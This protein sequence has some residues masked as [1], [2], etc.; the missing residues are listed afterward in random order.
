MRMMSA[1]ESRIAWTDLPADVRNGVQ[2][3]LGDRVVEALSQPGGFSPGTADRVRTAKG[4]RAFVK[5]VHPNLNEHSPGLHRREARINAALPVDV[6]APQ[7]IGGYDDGEWVA[8]VLE[9]IE[10]RHPVTPWVKV[11][12]D[13]VLAALKDLARTLTPPPLADLPSAR[14]EF[15]EDLRGW[16]RVAEDPPT[17]LDPWVKAN[18]SRL[19]EM[20]EPGIT[21]LDGDTGV[22]LDIRADNLLIRPDGRV[23]IIGWPWLCRGPAWLDSA[24]LMINVQLYRGHDID[25][26]LEGIARDFD[27]DIGALRGVL[28]GMAGFFVDAARTPTPGIPTVTAWRR[29]Q[30]DAL[31]SW[32]AEPRRD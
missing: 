26:L 23:V 30:G 7:F 25:A 6:P 19:G 12:L 10:G 2:E 16:Q 4:R 17:D 1:T 11:E 28:A 21:A 20:T 22:H 27:A 5:A 32:L 14:A 29:A 18:L 9:D 3:I 31:V 13:A 15:G 24:L 8:V